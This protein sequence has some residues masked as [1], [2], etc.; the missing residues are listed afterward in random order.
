MRPP[1]YDKILVRALVDCPS[2]VLGNGSTRTIKAGL[3]CVMSRTDAEPYILR[4][5]MAQMPWEN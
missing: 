5:Q 2:V 3:P 1:K 4:G